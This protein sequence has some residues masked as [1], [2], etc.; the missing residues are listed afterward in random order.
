M[1]R[2]STPLNPNFGVYSVHPPRCPTYY[3]INIHKS[4]LTRKLPR[5]ACKSFFKLLLSFRVKIKLQTFIIEHKVHNIA[6]QKLKQT[7]VAKIEIGFYSAVITHNQGSAAARQPLQSL[8]F[9]PV[10][11]LN[12]FCCHIWVRFTLHAWILKGWFPWGL[13]AAG[14]H[15]QYTI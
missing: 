15:N 7:L 13:Q 1:H 3:I 4:P 10:W 14:A 6:V 2:V 8:K 11:M 9:K 12:C 5:E